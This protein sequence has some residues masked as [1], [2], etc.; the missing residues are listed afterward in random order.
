[1]T[2]GAGKRY[3]ETKLKDA[4][5][6]RRKTIRSTSEFNQTRTWLL[7]IAIAVGN[8]LLLSRISPT[9]GVVFPLLALANYL[10][11][12][13]GEKRGRQL[14]KEEMQLIEMQE[15]TL[16]A[17]PAAETTIEASVLQAATPEEG[18]PEK[19]ALEQTTLE[20]T[21]AEKPA[22]EDA[23][24][25]EENMGQDERLSN[26]R[27]RLEEY[28]ARLQKNRARTRIDRHPD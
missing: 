21:S 1:M 24:L 3:S 28:Q 12:R 8:F 2:L 17:V 14:N 23:G 7:I 15:E 10:A 5:R 16:P 6:K 18:T 19:T 27:R 25:T 20:E 4:A 22:R 13:R 11:E 26:S 9:W